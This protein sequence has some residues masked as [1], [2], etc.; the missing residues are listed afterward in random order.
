MM[1]V[2]LAKAGIREPPPSR[3][4]Y[5]QWLLDRPV[6]PGDDKVVSWGFVNRPLRR[7]LCLEIQSRELS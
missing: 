1:A 2:M 3:F 4:Y 7:Y 5:W 6:R